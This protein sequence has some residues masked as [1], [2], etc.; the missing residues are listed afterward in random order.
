MLGTFPT[1]NLPSVSCLQRS[2]RSLFKPRHSAPK[3]I[4]AAALDPRPHLGSSRLGNFIFG[5][6]PLGK[7]ILGK[8]PRENAFGN[9]PNTFLNQ[10]NYLNQWN[11]LKFRLTK[12]WTREM[13]TKLDLLQN[14]PKL[15][16]IGKTYIN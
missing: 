11:L 6:L 2:A 9:V 14:E 15:Q 4:L 1:G 12:I 8:S 10:F 7:L 16:R 3:P 5:K 13:L